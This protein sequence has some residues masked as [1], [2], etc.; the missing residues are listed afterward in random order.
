MKIL[1]EKQKLKG[2]ALYIKCRFYSYTRNEKR[3]DKGKRKEK[4]CELEN[5]SFFSS[6][7]SPEKTIQQYKFPQGQTKYSLCDYT[8]FVILLYNIYQ[9][10][11]FY[12]YVLH[13]NGSFSRLQPIKTAI[14]RS[15]RIMTFNFIETAFSSKSS[16]CYLPWHMFSGG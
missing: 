3:Y 9:H 12:F 5:N 15:K 10:G 4:H 8:S 11:V 16:L 2:R 7:I 6:S 13:D 14:Q 1:P